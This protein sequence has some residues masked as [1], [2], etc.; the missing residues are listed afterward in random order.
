MTRSV[1]GAACLALLLPISAVGQPAPLHVYL[2]HSGN[3][4]VGTR[5]VNEVRE[6]L[7]TSARYPLAASIDE[8]RI[9]LVVVST[10][11]DPNHP[12]TTSAIGWTSC[13]ANMRQRGG[14][15]GS[16]SVLGP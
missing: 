16:R 9:V 4:A 13:T 6:A 10:D 14:G 1:F 15:V 2:Q 8:A 11:V 5:V 7:R 3:D 12:G